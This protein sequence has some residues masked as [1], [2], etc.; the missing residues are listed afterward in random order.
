MWPVRW[1]A[2]RWL[3]VG[4]HTNRSGPSVPAAESPPAVAAGPCLWV[5][6]GAAR[7][8]GVG[9][10]QTC[11]EALGSTWACFQPAP[12][13]VRCG[14]YCCCDDR[15]QP[16]TQGAAL[17]TL[18]VGTCSV[19]CRRADEVGAAAAVTTE[20]RSKRLAHCDARF[21][22]A[23]NL[24]EGADVLARH[25]SSLPPV[26]HSCWGCSELVQLA[27]FQP[28]AICC[29]WCT[30]VR[31]NS[32]RGC[33][34]KLCRRINEAGWLD[35]VD[36]NASRAHTSGRENPCELLGWQCVAVRGLASILAASGPGRERALA[37]RCSAAVRPPLHP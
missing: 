35:V 14:R 11:C 10:W 5:V 30:R 1:S 13:P 6:P 20:V 34:H 4:A 37:A 36:N 28:P 9:R 33:P 24:R 31:C 2:Q 17:L 12:W 19:D 3:Q 27:S 7:L 8:V 16:A 32:R 15:Q 22:L 21:L 18:C 23:G 29:H 26:T 25:E